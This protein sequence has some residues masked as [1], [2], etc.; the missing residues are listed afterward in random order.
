MAFEKHELI[1]G[2]VYVAVGSIICGYIHNNLLSAS[3]FQSSLVNVWL[4][5]ILAISWME[6]WVK[7]KAPLLPKYIALDVGR[8]VFKALNVVETVFLFTLWMLPLVGGSAS[9]M[10]SVRTVQDFHLLSILVLF[11]VFI[12]TPLL[13]D[14][15][16]FIILNTIDDDKEHTGLAL[17]LREEVGWKGKESFSFA[18]ST[19][20][21]IVYVFIE[22]VKIG[23]LA[24]I[25]YNFST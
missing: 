15:A 13:T 17:R 2:L 5:F 10:N 12:V 7:F 6:A 19:K 16:K 3:K 1:L 23:L 11:E 22:F 25:G 20:W 14:R 24:K 4:G 8:H 9:S 21:H 18:P